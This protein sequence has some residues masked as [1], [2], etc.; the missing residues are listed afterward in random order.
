M[1]KQNEIEAILKRL[2]RYSTTIANAYIYHNGIIQEDAVN[3][4][5]VE[6]LSKDRMVWRPDDSEHVHL[7][8][9]LTKLLDRALIRSSRR[10]VSIDMGTRILEIEDNLYFYRRAKT[11][12]SIQ[13]IERYSLILQEQVY[14]LAENIVAATNV[15]RSKVMDGFSDVIDLELR[16][17]ENEKTIDRARNLNDALSLLSVNQLTEFSGSDIFLTRLFCHVLPTTL[18]SCREEL[19]ASLHLLTNM[20]FTLQEQ[21]YRSKLIDSAL[22]RYNKYPAFIP[23]TLD[24]CSFIPP[25]VNFIDAHQIEAFPNIYG[26][27]FTQALSNLLQGIGRSSQ[28]DVSPV[29]TELFITVDDQD[30]EELVEISPM[31]RDFLT[32]LDKADVS[33][34]MHS[35]LEFY[36]ITNR[37]YSLEIWLMSV[38][39]SFSSLSEH[40][41]QFYRMTMIEEV[42]PIYN[43]NYLV[44]DILI[45]SI[46]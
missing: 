43:G 11:I 32:L 1:T 21:H 42:M 26:S 46:V 27:I 38:I 12:A 29:E 40:D 2:G 22:K 20:L 37:E 41:K 5:V 39:N 24:Q 18:D 31:I 34:L 9:D 8:N 19:I 14:D 13:D 35:A 10:H 25:E 33:P 44:N 30:A 45:G 16:V 7:T 4:R 17:E 15:F 28:N 23:N 3:T 36:K 6:Q